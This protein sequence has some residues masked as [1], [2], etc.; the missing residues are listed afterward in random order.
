MFEYIFKRIIFE[1]KNFPFKFFLDQ[2]HN[3]KNS[4]TKNHFLGSVKF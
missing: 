2:N 4:L 1:K 3:I